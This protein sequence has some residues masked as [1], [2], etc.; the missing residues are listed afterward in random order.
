[1]Q[2]LVEAFFQHWLKIVGFIVVTV[3]SFGVVTVAGFKVGLTVVT[4]F[5][6]VGLTVK[7]C[8]NDNQSFG[9]CKIIKGH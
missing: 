6:V 4:G 1:M 2:G 8:L 3:T 9:S 5:G 7:S